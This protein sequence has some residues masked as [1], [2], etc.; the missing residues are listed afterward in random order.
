MAITGIKLAVG[1][2]GNVALATTLTN[3]PF[4][5]TFNRPVLSRQTADGHHIVVANGAMVSSYAPA[6]TTKLDPAG[7]PQSVNGFSPNVDHFFGNTKKQGYDARTPSNYSSAKRIALPWSPTPNDAVIL[8]DAADALIAPGQS[9]ANIRA[10]VA[11]GWH[12]VHFVSS[13]PATAQSRM[14]APPAGYWVG[15]TA[16]TID[17]DIDAALAALPSLAL[18]PGTYP[19]PASVIARMD[20]N[21]GAGLLST[22]ETS[23]EGYEAF[24]PQQTAP[25]V[26]GNT[27]WINYGR[28]LGKTMA[29]A[30]LHVV[31][32][33]ATAAEKRALLVRQISIG[34]Q[35]YEGCKAI[36]QWQS[37]LG[38]A[39][40]P[41][42]ESLSI[43]LYLWASGKTSELIDLPDT[44][45]A[46]L[47]GQPFKFTPSLIAQLAPHRDPT[48]IFMSRIRSVVSVTGSAGAYV[49]TH[50]TYAQDNSQQDF[51]TLRMI[52]VSDAQET[53][54]TGNNGSTF[55][56]TLGTDN[57]DFTVASQLTPPLQA[58]D[59]I[60]FAAPHA[61]S[62]G[63]A[64]WVIASPTLVGDERYRYFNAS[65]QTP[66]RNLVFLAWP[67]LVAKAI[68]FW[69][70]GGQWDAAKEYVQRAMLPNT[71][72]S[73]LGDFPTH[74]DQTD[75]YQMTQAFWDAH[76]TALGL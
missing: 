60:Y 57:G 50:A 25:F 33:V 63:D 4:S 72:M 6:Q 74:A 58:G 7:A 70:T 47:F 31:G 46:C 37:G 52:R 59:E 54:V 11:S 2:G 16:A 68:G 24:V 14:F 32:N 29:I 10:G 41:Q 8:Q 18:T 53:I 42:W 22:Q 66:Y 21:F 69:Q 17:I 64:D 39:G 19:T 23:G 30:G 55:V 73:G 62:V 12:S 35:I 76:K 56:N 71:P 5:L 75:G 9:T 40:H 38:L 13:I 36:G 45:S 27:Y 15:K 20:K 3:G 1:S 34:R 67:L 48:K 43:M 61:I 49:V 65:A 51:T 44:Y 28:S 26:D